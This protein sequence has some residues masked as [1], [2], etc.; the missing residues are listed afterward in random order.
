M[1]SYTLALIAT[2]R[3][4]QQIRTPR[5][6]VIPTG[7]AH[8]RIVNDAVEDPRILLLTLPSRGDCAPQIYTRVR[9]QDRIRNIARPRSRRLLHRP[10]AYERSFVQIAMATISGMRASTRTSSS[11]TPEP[12]P[13]ICCTTPSSTTASLIAIILLVATTVA[14]AAI[15]IRRKPRA[16]ESRHPDR[17]VSQ[18]NRESRSGG[19]PAF[20]FPILPLAILTAGIAFLL[21]PLSA[22]IW[23]H[24]PQ[25]SFLQFPWRLLA[26]LAPIFAL[27]PRPA[28]S[29]KVRVPN[30]LRQHRKAWE[31]RI[32]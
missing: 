12:H 23:N 29:P 27:V 4:I 13:T 15:L 8:S 26:I 2:L 18:L 22:P 5:T 24:T 28:P 30:L 3:I 21:T 19:T 20:V 1:G 7:V 25:A 10:A 9:P 32:S 17:S 14:L 31:V 11:N 16:E 6:S